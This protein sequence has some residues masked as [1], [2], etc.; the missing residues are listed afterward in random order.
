MRMLRIAA[1]NEDLSEDS[2]GIDEFTP[3]T[4]EAEVGYSC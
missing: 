3:P 4:K 1:L 2:S